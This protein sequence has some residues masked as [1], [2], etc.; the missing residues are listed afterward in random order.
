MAGKAAELSAEQIAEKQRELEELL[1]E[2]RRREEDFIREEQERAKLEEQRKAEEESERAE[3]ERLKGLE[4]IQELERELEK[5]REIQARREEARR[6]RVEEAQ[7]G[8]NNPSGED[9]QILA[10]L[11][12]Q[13]RKQ[14]REKI[15]AEIER[16]RQKLEN[17]VLD[18]SVL[19]RSE[20]NSEKASFRD[21]Q[22]LVPK[23]KGEN[24]GY[25][26]DNWI[27]EVDN[28][29][30]AYGWSSVQTFI[31][32]RKALDGLAKTWISHQPDIRTWKQLQEALQKEFGKKRLQ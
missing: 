23:F 22:E 21:T 11:Q 1:E 4:K 9:E 26:L 12:E 18:D 31:A 16:L 7:R 20:N 24:F 25:P 14:N 2:D 30:E 3:L 10:E 17:N 27:R 19:T 29:S 8:F 6:Q 28:S 32:A 5:R 15:R 13:E